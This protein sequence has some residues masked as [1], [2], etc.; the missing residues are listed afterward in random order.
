MGI[1]QCSIVWLHPDSE[2]KATT[3]VEQGSNNTYPTSSAGNS[4]GPGTGAGA[5]TRAGTCAGTCAKPEEVLTQTK[6]SKLA[7]SYGFRDV[8][9]LRRESYPHQEG[10]QLFIAEMKLT[11]LKHWWHGGG[12]GIATTAK[13]LVFDM[14]E[15]LEKEGFEVVKT[16]QHYIS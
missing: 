9:A 11:G 6:L 15:L 12:Q 8:T 5:G 13:A 2:S 4:T 3:T 1:Y 10:N 7:R 14:R 16:R